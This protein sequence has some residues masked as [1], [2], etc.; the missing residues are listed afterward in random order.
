M[1]NSVK[2]TLL[3][4]ALW[5]LFQFSFSSG[6][7]YQNRDQ[8]DRFIG[9]IE[10]RVALDLPKLKL[11]NPRFRTVV[12]ESSVKDY[13]QQLNTSLA[14]M[15]SPVRVARLQDVALEESY[16]GPEY[17][18][19]LKTSEQ[20]IP[21]QL[22]GV[23]PS[24]FATFTLL[25]PFLAVIF[26]MFCYKHETALQR[27]RKREADTPAINKE[28]RLVVNLHNKTISN[29]L[30]SVVV[31]LSNKPFCF[32]LALVDYCLEHESPS[33]NQNKEVP[34][35]ILHLANKYFFRLIELGHTKRKKP[36]FGTNLDKTLSEV[37]SA[38]DE[39]FH[40]YADAKDRF[41]PPKAQGEGSR[42]KVHNYSLP[43]IFEDQVEFIGK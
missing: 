10:K 18:R 13:L 25:A 2:G 33:L 29:G 23:S 8:T 35:E 28:A 31:P 16:S 37:R 30:D 7:Y 38:L 40:D 27:R 5:L 11:S 4:C 22:Y 32:Y 24:P 43:H 9:N 19:E 26:V 20:V 14:E 1:S 39:V 34:D 41:Y 36:D 17:L 12:H 3:F 21:L 42:S 15:D 6:H